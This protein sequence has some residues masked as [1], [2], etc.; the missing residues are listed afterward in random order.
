MVIHPTK[1]RFMCVN[2]TYNDIFI[3]DNANICYTDSYTYLGTPISCRSVSEQVQQHLNAK[4][5][6]VLK[7][8]SFLEKKQ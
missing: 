5:S 3:L 2:S 4:S 8:T 1:S 6:H 7:F